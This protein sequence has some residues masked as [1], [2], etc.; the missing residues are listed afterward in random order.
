MEAL[1]VG[2]VENPGV[3]MLTLVANSQKLTAVLPLVSAKK[4]SESVSQ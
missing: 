2:S 4:Q 1:S 3:I